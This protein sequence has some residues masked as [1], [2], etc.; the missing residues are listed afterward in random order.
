MECPLSFLT[1][2]TSLLPRSEE[3]VFPG[4]ASKAGTAGMS[5]HGR[6]S[7]PPS[8]PSPTQ[9]MAGVPAPIETPLSARTLETSWSMEASQPGKRPRQ[10]SPPS[11]SRSQPH[12]TLSPPLPFRQPDPVTGIQPSAP[13]RALPSA[14]AAIEASPY[15]GSW[16]EPAAEA[17]FSL[18]S[19][20][21]P[22]PET[23]LSLGSWA[24]PA[25]AAAAGGMQERRAAASPGLRLA[26]LAEAMPTSL[27]TDVTERAQQAHHAQQQDW[28]SIQPSRTL[29]TGEQEGKGAGGAGG[30]VPQPP[31]AGSGDS[32]AE[33]VSA[34]PHAAGHLL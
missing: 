26:E 23:S 1:K 33:K 10:R 16:A 9:G 8:D 2:L 18:G 19:W 25:A 4:T 5:G 32:V 13:L 15:L 3:D 7:V 24:E 11:A 22:A 30:E 20:A 6:P 12:T 28:T 14:P 21:E 17:S 31:R 27:W 34:V 29:P